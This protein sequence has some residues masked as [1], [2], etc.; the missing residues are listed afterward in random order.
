MNHIGSFVLALISCSTS[1]AAERPTQFGD[2]AFGASLQETKRLFSMRTGV[3]IPE[4]AAATEAT[5]VTPVE[6]IEAT[7]GFFADAP[8]ESWLLEFEGGKF[9]K[10][11]VVVKTDGRAK[12]FF[13]EFKQTLL[14]KYGSATREKSTS[15]VWIFKPV[16]TDNHARSI[17]LDLT[18]LADTATEP[19]LSVVYTDDIPKIKALEIPAAKGAQ[20]PAA[21]TPP[22][23]KL[24][25]KAL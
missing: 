20:P 13:R 22:V 6:K 24:N 1:F 3:T 11:T 19:R 7:G 18:P 15:A 25:P 5:A 9:Y 23:K 14:A 12:A 21:V 4:P 10:A 16:L 17:N 2:I 8:V